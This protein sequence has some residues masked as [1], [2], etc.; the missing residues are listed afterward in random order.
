MRRV[1]GG[2]V[3]HG[4][5]QEP[6]V[7]EHVLGVDDAARLLVVGDE[8][9]TPGGKP[10]GVERRHHAASAAPRVVR[11]DAGDVRVVAGVLL[12]QE[13]AVAIDGDVVGLVQVRRL[14]AVE[15]QLDRAA[16]ARVLDVLERELP[17]TAAVTR[18]RGRPAALR[19]HEVEDVGMLRVPGAVLDPIQRHA[20]GRRLGVL[21]H[22]RLVPVDL[23]EV[24]LDRRALA[25]LGAEAGIAAHRLVDQ[26]EHRADAVREA[27]TVERVAPAALDALVDPQLAERAVLAA[28]RHR[29]VRAVVRRH[30]VLPREQAEPRQLL[31]RPVLEHSERAALVA[32]L[33]VGEV[34]AAVVAAIAATALELPP[35]AERRRAEARERVALSGEHVA[36][37]ARVGPAR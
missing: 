17:Q 6:A 7:A 5:E 2:L 11:H 13:V 20:V 27:G 24:E 16:Q 15:Q 37:E 1:G 21:P 8:A 10:L 34:D 3:D 9:R 33:L 31:G 32:V 30:R 35:G 18:V 14:R 26:V 19:G 25:V 12:D 22:A 29:G 23:R 36:G 28:D 4:R